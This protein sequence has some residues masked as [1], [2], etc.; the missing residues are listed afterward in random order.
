MDEE[1]KKFTEAEII[2]GSLFTLGIDVLGAFLDGVVIGLVITPVIKGG[3]TFF[4]WLW[5]KSKGDKSSQK[6]GKQVAKYAVN[7]VPVLPTT[8]T[9]FAIG[10]YSHNHPKLAAVE[11]KIK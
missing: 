1:I 9:I 8:F 3:V 7:C 10:V 6:I 11:T 4:M 5:F 2:L